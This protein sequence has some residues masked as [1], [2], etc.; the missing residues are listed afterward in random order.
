VVVT[1]DMP[2]SGI[3]DSW[4]ETKEVFK[5]HQIPEDSNKALKEFLSGDQLQQVI[6]QLNEV[7]GS[8]EST[9]I[10]GG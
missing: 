5:I 4:N 6:S 2:I 8:S 3:V 1:E 10:E 7:I 9:C